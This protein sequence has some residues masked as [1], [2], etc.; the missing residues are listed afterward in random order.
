MSEED[1]SSMMDKLKK[2]ATEIRNSWFR[3]LDKTEYMIELTKMLK[4]MHEKESLEEYFGKDEKVLKYFM[5]DF[6]QEVI[7]NIVIQP[8]IFGENGDEIALELLLNIYKLFLKFHKNSNYS[9]LFKKIRFIFNQEQARNSFFS[10]HK[11]EDGEKKYDFIN[12]NAKYCSGFE[13]NTENNKYNIGDEVDICLENDRYE[14]KPIDKKVWIRGKIKNIEND[15]YIIQYFGNKELNIPLNNYTIFPKGTKTKD[16]DWRINLKKYD[17]IDCYDRSKWYP[18]TIVDIT[19]EGIN[20]EYK[21]IKYE[22]GFRL[23]PDNFKNLEDENDTYDKHL[24]IWKNTNSELEILTDDDKQKYIGDGN[25]YNENIYFYS[26][27]I[28]KFNTYSACQQ[29]VLNNY[30]SNSNE[31]KDEMKLMTEKLEND[32][33]ILIDE[34]YNYEVDGKKNF[35]LGKSKNFYYYYALLLKKIEKENSFSKF[36]EILKDQPNTEEIYNIFCI[37]TYCFPYLHKDYFVE[38]YTIIKESLLNYINNLKDKEMRNLPKDLIDIV[39]NLLYKVGVY[40]EA[41]SPENGDKKEMIDLHDVITLTLSMKTIKTSIFDRRLQGI[42]ALNEFIDKNQSKKD[43]SKKIVELIKKN[44]IISEIFGANY[45]SQIISKSNE[46]IKLLLLENELNEDEMK[47]IWSCTKRGDLEAKLTIL[48]LLSE[49]APHLKE[50]YIEMLLNSIKSNV[51]EKQNKQEIELVFKLSTQY[52]NEKNIENCCDYL[53]QCLLM[54]KNTNIKNDPVMEKL[55]EIIEKDN[56][57]LKKVFDICENF[58]KRN[59]KTISSF[60]ILFEMIGKFWDEK[61]ENEIIKDFIKD[62]HL[63]RLFEDNFKLYVEH[64]KNLLKKNNIFEADIIDKYIIDG[65]SHLENIKKRMEIYPDLINKFY[66]DYDFTPFLKDV[67]LNDP[68]CP[69]DELIFYDFLK[70]YISNNENISDDSIKR[71]EKIRKELFELLSEK[72]HTEITV[73]QIK[74]FIALFFDMN[75]DKIKVKESKCDN[76]KEIVYENIDIEDIDSLE[77]LDKLWNIIFKIEGKNVLSTAINIIFQIYKNKNIEK[78]LEKFK[79]LI[80][81]E[82]ST[83]EIINKCITLLKLIINESEKNCLFKPKSHLC[84]LKDCLIHLPLELKEKTNINIDDIKKYLLL[85]NTTLNEL[86]VFMSQ[87]YNLPPEYLSF[88]FSDKYLKHIKKNNLIEKDE[89]DE[90]NNNNSLYELIIKLDDNLNSNLKPNEKIIFNKK[91]MEKEK[92]IINNEMNPKLIN[93]FKE[94][95]NGFTNGTGKMER[96]GIAKFIKS[97]TKNKSEVKENDTRVS[98]LLKLDKEKKGYLNEEEFIGFYRDALSK[99]KES[100]VW[101]NLKEMGVNENLRKKDESYQINYIENEKLPRYILGNDFSF[102]EN[103]IQKY[104]KNPNFNYSLIEFLLSLTT[105]ENIYNDTLDNLFNNDD[106]NKNKDSFIN[107]CLNENTNENYA[108]QNYIFIIIES[109]LYD[110]EIYFYNKYNI[111]SNDFIIFNDNQ[112]KIFSEKYEPFD[113]GDKIEKKINFIKSL[114]KSENLQKII[115]IANNLL[116]RL[117]K[118]KIDYEDINVFPAL[119]ECCLRAL[120]I[121]NCINNFSCDDNQENK[122]N[123]NCLKELKEKNIYNLGFCNISSLFTDVDFKKEINNLSYL[124]LVNNLINYLISKKECDNQLNRGCL[125]LLINLLSSNKQLLEEYTSKDEKK[126]QIMIDMFKTYFSDNES[127]IKDYFVQNLTQS[128]NKAKNTQKNDYIQFLFQLV[129]SFLENV[130]NTQMNDE[131]T[132]SNKDNNFILDNTFFDLYN[133]LYNI[134]S[135]NKDNESSNKNTF[136]F[137]IHELIMKSLN[138]IEQKK[139]VDMKLFMSLLQILKTQMKGNDQIKNE[140]LFKKVNG[141]SFFEFLLK[142]TIDE[143]NENNKKEESLRDN[144]DNDDKEEESRYICLE[145]IMEEKKED[146]SDKELIEISNE[147]LSECFEGTKDPKLISELLKLINLLKGCIKD[148]NDDDDDDDDNGQTTL[149]SHNYFSKSCGH[150]G[151]KNLGCICYMNSIIQQM[152]MVPTFRYAIMSADDG[153]EEK[154]NSNVDDDNLLHQLQNMYTYLTYSNKMDYNPREFCYSYKDFDGK[155]MNVRAQQDSQE[156]YN[157]FCDKVENC[158]KKT[159]YKYIVSDVFAGKSCNYVFCENCKHISYRFEDFYNLTLEVKNITNL[160]DSLQKLNDPE[161]IDDFKCSNCN[162]KVRIKKVTTL[163]KLPNVLVVHLKRFYLD[164]QTFKTKKINSQFEFANNLNLKNYCIEEIKKNIPKN[165]TETSDKNDEKD[166]LEIYNKED[167]YYE[168]VLKGINVH[169]GSASGGHYFSFIDVNRDG[170][171]NILNNYI[172]EN[173]LQFNDSRVSNF[174]TETI[175]KECFGGTAGGSSYENHQNAYLLIYERKKM[176]PVRVLLD[177]KDIDKYKEKDNI[178]KIDKDNKSKINKEY[179]LSRINTDKKESDLFNKI[180]F[181]EEKNEYYKYIPYYNIPKYAPRKIYNEIMKENNNTSSSK[182]TGNKN[183]KKYKNYLHTLLTILKDNKDFVINN[184]NYNDSLKEIIIT[185]ALNDFFK[186]IT[187]HDSFDQEQKEQINT[188]FSFI[189]KNLIKPLIKEDTNI[190]II[191]YIKKMLMNANYSK[192]IFFSQRSSSDDMIIN[193]ENAKDIS[194]ILFDIM[195]IMYKNEEKHDLKVM[196]LLFINLIRNNISYGYDN[197]DD[198][199]IVFIYQLLYK[200]LFIDEMYVKVY[201][202][203]HLIKILLEKIDNE[204][205]KIRSIIYDLLLYLIKQTKKYNKELFD[206]GENEKEGKYYYE[207]IIDLKGEHIELLFKENFEL[208]KIILII[209]SYDNEYQNEL[210]D[211]TISKTYKIVQTDNNKINNFIDIL[212]SFIKINDKYVFTKLCNLMGYPN[213]IIN[214]IP[215]KKKSHDYNYNDDSDNE[216]STEPP[217]QKWPIFGE[218]L[219]NGDINRHIYE[220]VSFN[221]RKEAKCLLGLLFPKENILETKEKDENNDWN[222]DNNNQDENE[223]KIEISNELKKNIILDLLNNCFGEGNNY[224]LFKYIY[225]TPTRNLVYKNLYE[226]IIKFLQDQSYIYPDEY[227]IK[228]KEYITNIEKE[229]NDVIEK[230]KNEYNDNNDISSDNDNDNSSKDNDEFKC[231]DENMK[232]FIG[233]N[234]DI[235]PGEIVREEIIKI[236]STSYLCLYKIQYFTKYFNTEELRNS[237]LNKN[238]TNTEEINKK[239][240]EDEDK[241]KEENN[242]NKENKG[243]DGENKED[244]KEKENKDDKEE[245]KNENKEENMEEKIKENDSKKDDAKKDDENK[246]D[247]NKENEN[248]TEVKDNKDEEKEK[249]EKRDEDNID[250]DKKDGDKKDGEKKDDKKE[251]EKKE[252]GKKEEEKKGEEKKG[253]EKKD[254]KKGEEKKEDDKKVDD[255]KVDEKEEDQKKEDDKKDEEK[256]DEEKKEEQKKED[257]KKD[258]EKKEEEKKDEEKEENQKRE[259]EKKE[260]E[261]KEEEK[262][263]EEKKEEKKKEEEKKDEEKTE[264]QK[265]EDDKK[266]E[267]KVEEEKKEEHKEEEKKEDDKKVEDNKVDDKKEEEKKEEEKKEEEK[268]EEEKKEEEK[269]EEKKEDEKKEEEKNEEEKKNDEEEKKEEEKKE[270]EKKVEEKKEEEKKEEEKKEENE[271]NKEEEKKEELNQK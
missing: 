158:L 210:Y 230:A 112:Y 177:E 93:I 140:I 159:K 19:E 251:E 46:I 224:S 22:I 65:F 229:I 81:E 1:D 261:K 172:K 185:S 102:I 203:R 126:K 119:F 176:S 233:F 79:T 228:E 18:A 254:D 116:D 267:K 220:Y 123:K 132:T 191:K 155:P 7:S 180:F 204:N 271:E 117:L 239:N 130:I 54:S 145:N 89:I 62:R 69:N 175:P 80:K 236:G 42:K 264:D 151:L 163:S 82:S 227:K 253:E 182:S 205:D 10:D 134:I 23:Y 6:F 153:E 232:K 213:L 51:D 96:E 144:N 87:L 27:R 231:Y 137:K 49:L 214:Q 131:E 88:S 61:N 221:H 26:K 71:K 241:E 17:V 235:I 207:Y 269:K 110:L 48:N 270:E 121:I 113:N 138:N 34:Y 170:K 59:E 50:N 160:K 226:E 97:V 193:K 219:I 25:R 197:D 31:E 95:F 246:E 154:S 5:E 32:T 37:L 143:I 8:K 237:L 33:D 178:I 20:D 84:L 11:Y 122:E 91:V 249:E 115:N 179:D 64:T 128:I 135:E 217:K 56:K 198:N 47:L 234:S 103:L 152:Y 223:N 164:Y 150:V 45:H 60:S 106:E 14:T 105:N 57:Y 250:E 94:W 256:K 109:I 218:R 240:N 189:I 127:S 208:F 215:R 114:V 162:Q 200:L 174:E 243:K 266:E 196:V 169:T 35:I 55:L 146:N 21:N 44:E 167:D 118:L 262:K 216:D 86:K 16:W 52:N 67:L 171:N 70:N 13:K 181:D 258:E 63:L 4:E 257:Y 211:K 165:E 199:T 247:K 252:E 58:I 36:I 245:E 192:K 77:G 133:S 2:I 222:D 129:N 72:N 202:E 90:S 40:N 244:E 74:L 136:L 265:K 30:N 268:K 108:E 78:L 85:G 157:N 238:T 259:E 225:L 141:Y 161:I 73:E 75:K 100:T 98:N 3:D 29:R 124:N 149:S 188:V 139:K 194:D 183:K 242:D 43:I 66:T 184:E 156:F 24:D 76:N 39:S 107:K 92:L 111:E 68:V 168:Y 260:K 12:F 83:P 201:L 166:N 148:L 248:Q 101:D 173:W 190:N 187:S 263:E 255:K 41:T 209:L 147:F 206:L 38:N 9:P 212:C 195:K 186:S 15:E 142:K 99:K 53:C 125:D 28:Q 120:K 104:Y